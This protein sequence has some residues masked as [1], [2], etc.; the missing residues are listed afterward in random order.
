MSEH[1]EQNPFRALFPK[2]KLSQMQAEDLEAVV[3]AVRRVK[4]EAEKVVAVEVQATFSRYVPFQRLVDIEDTLCKQYGLRSFAIVP[5]FPEYT[6]RPAYLRDVAD[7]AARVG[8]L[9]HGFF[10]EATY[11]DDAQHGVVE[12]EIPFMSSGID[13]VNSVNTADLLSRILESWF[14]IQRR[15]EIKESADAAAATRER[16][17]DIDKLLMEYEAQA[18]AQAAKLPST[19]GETPAVQEGPVLAARR[20]NVLFPTEPHCEQLSETAYYFGNMKFETEGATPI[21]GEVLSE[22]HPVSIGEVNGPLNGVTLLGEV[23]AVTT[24]EIRNGERLAVTIGITDGI[25]S[26]H[27]KKTAPPEEMPWLG[28][29]KRGM[30]VAVRCRAYVDK[31]DNEL[32]GEPRAISKIKRILREDNAPEKRVELHLHTTMSQMDAYID[33]ADMVATATRWG[34]P[35]IAVTDHGNVQSFPEVMLEKEKQKSPVKILYGM[36]A[37]FVNDQARAVWGT[38]R[39]ALTDEMVVFDIETTGLDVRSC[40]IT[41]IGAVKIRNGEVVEEFNTFVNPEMPIPEEIVKLTSI[42]DEMVADAPKIQEALSAFLTF[43]GDSLLIAHNANFD[44]GFIRAAATECGLPFENTYLDTV[45][46][47]RYLNPDLK[48]HKLDALVEHYK[49]GEFHHHRACDDARVLALIFFE[50]VRQL[51]EE[52]IRDVGTMVEAMSEKSDPLKLKPHHMI[53]FAKNLTG[54]KNLYK[55][56][57]YSYLSCFKRFPRIPKSVLEDHREGLIIGSACEAGELYQALL[58]NMADAA[59]EEIATFYDY[60]EIQPLCNNRFLVEEG[61]VPSDE[62]LRDLNRRIIALGDKLGKPVCATCDAHFMNPEDELY[63]KIILKGQK[64]SDGDRDTGIYLRTTDEMLA[65]F[66]YLGEDVARRVVIENPNIIADMCEEIRP[67]PEG[68]YEPKME[69]AEEDLVSSC[70][71]RATEM[72]GYDDGTGVKI[73]E[74]VSNRLTRELDAIIS[75]GFAVLYMIAVKLVAYSEAQGYLVGSRGS[76]GSSFVASMSGISEVNPLPPHYY[77]PHCHYSEFITDGSYG[78]GFDL[79]DAVCPK[80]GTLYRADGHDIP[81]ETFLGFKGDKSP[82]IDLNFSGD[83]QGRVH[84]YTEELFGEGNVFRAGTTST[85]ADKTAYGYVLKYLEEKG[86]SLPRAE[87][88]QLVSRVAGV[89]RTTGQH[90]AGIIVVPKEN[91][92]YEFSPVQHPADDPH[93]DIITTHFQFSYLHDT[94][95]KLDEL[96]HDI[97]TKYKMLERY[98]NTSV[99]DVKMNDPRVYRLFTSVEPLGITPDMI[100][101]C[102][103]GTYG[104]PEMGTHFIQGVLEDAQPKNFADLLQI[105]GLTHGTNVW[106]GNAQDLIKAGIC[107]IS[108]VIGTRDG[109]MLDLI[110]YGMPNIEAFNIME[111]VRKGKGLKPEWEESMLAHGV[112]EWYIGSCKK[113]KYMFPKAHAAAYVMSAI[114]LGWYKLEFPMEFYAAFLSVAPGGFDA[115]IVMQGK[116]YVRSVIDATAK[117]PSGEQTQKDKELINTLQLVEEAMA[118][119]IKFLPPHLYKSDYKYFLPEEGKIRMPF[120][121]LSG[122]GETAAQ[123]IVQARDEGEIYSVEDLRIRAGVSKAVIETLRAA[124]ALEGLTETNQFSLF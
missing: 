118:R 11:L 85:L 42:T 116:S 81:F 93:S 114:R 58:D 101:G 56:I 60:L 103:L 86:L 87:V 115:E 9:T 66:A 65:E 8:G 37:Y 78:S 15:F 117:K 38:A 43:C 82:D 119:G 26:F 44:C 112:P 25:Y 99:L 90:P 54:L 62:A 96:G 5:R 57:S 109:I 28:S 6:Y 50:M 47:S 7:C 110:R 120:I 124:K 76:V 113:I 36:E 40:R 48:K 91:E 35:A 61:K 24:K 20:A 49:L 3:E 32:C 19:E 55:L 64:F 98:T 29:I 105:S 46:L 111:S 39:P 63:R 68:R 88:D 72:Y 59:I 16:Q 52:G 95:L 70:W 77:C 14:G 2:A 10:D 22:I 79:P 92:I 13:L 122:L 23:F 4:K 123:K 106:L 121:A 102:K 21:F 51:N 71:K 30:S 83:V 1:L 33:P 12:V 53:I 100:G 94:I 27:L 89:K 17:Q 18:M 67:I 74:I 69:G 75:N 80:C 73:P 107:D 84:K 34:W 45:G 31:Y 108:K 41:E 97:P 104:L